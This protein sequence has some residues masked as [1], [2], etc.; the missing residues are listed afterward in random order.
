LKGLEVLARPIRQE[1]GVRKK[2]Q[3]NEAV[4]KTQLSQHKEKILNGK[5][6]CIDPSCVSTSSKPGWALFEQGKLT[7]CAA[8]DIPHHHD[9]HVRLNRIVKYFAKFEVDLVLIEGIP[10]RPIRSKQSAV[11]TGKVWMSAVGHG[12][13]VQAIGATKAAFDES[14]PVLTFP[15]TLWHRVSRGED[16]GVDGSV[17]VKSD[18]ADAVRIGMSAIL[19]VTSEV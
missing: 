17:V 10:V 16:W 4:C 11:Q 2:N 18:V 9:L 5:M 6:L 14:V 7:A 15:A 3:S 19:L 13:L 8:A 12:S 1:S